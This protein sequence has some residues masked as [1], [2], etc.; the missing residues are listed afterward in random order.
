MRN[1]CCKKERAARA[2][3]DVIVAPDSSSTFTEHERW[4]PNRVL[5]IIEQPAP[6]RSSLASAKSAAMSPRYRG[7]CSFAVGNGGAGYRPILSGVYSLAQKSG[8]PSLSA[9]LLTTGLTPRFRY[10]AMARS[11]ASDM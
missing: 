4:R 2:S 8:G 10:A 11:S 6:T 3:R 7:S 9:T 5:P 1:Q